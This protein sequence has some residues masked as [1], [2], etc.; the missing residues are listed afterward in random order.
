MHDENVVRSSSEG[1]NLTA[2]IVHE[3]GRAIVT[4]HYPSG[5]PFPVEADLCRQYGASR[6]VLREAVK[7]LAAKG[8]RLR[9]PV[10]AP[11]CDPK[12]SGIYSIPMCCAG[13]SSANSRSISSS[14]SPTRGLG[15]SRAPRHLRQKP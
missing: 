4:G 2:Q 3:L 1:R 9:E 7:M 10:K 13:S 11:P 8:L 12:T 6:P 15:S 14:S 5:Q